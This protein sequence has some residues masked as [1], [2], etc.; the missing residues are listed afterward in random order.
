MLRAL[1]TATISA[2]ALLMLALA[3]CDGGSSSASGQ[4]STTVIAPS[5]NSTVVVRTDTLSSTSTTYTVVRRKM[6]VNA[7]DT[8]ILSLDTLTYIGGSTVLD[9]AL[10]GQ[11]PCPESLGL[12]IYNLYGTEVT[13]ELWA[14]NSLA[15]SNG[16]IAGYSQEK[17]G[18]NPSFLADRDHNRWCTGWSGPDDFT[19]GQKDLLLVAGVPLTAGGASY[20]LVQGH[21]PEA[22]SSSI[23]VLDE[24]GRL[25]T[26]R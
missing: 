20:F 5:T 6:L 17:V 16:I 9:T 10:L 2:Q 22:T 12:T 7:S 15:Y 24:V 18:S 26:L 21:F 13:M 4:D 3:A 14:G 1:R 19:W 23:L 25:R 8:S 11:Q